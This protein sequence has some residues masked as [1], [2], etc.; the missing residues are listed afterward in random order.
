MKLEQQVVSLEIAKKLKELGVEQ[1]SLFYWH[2]SPYMVNP[3]QKYGVIERYIECSA[4]TVAELGELL[5]YKAHSYR[6]FN[7]ASFWC[8]FDTPDECEECGEHIVN[9]VKCTKSDTEANARGKMLVYLL[10][11]KLLVAKVAKGEKE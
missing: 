5:P 9:I 4:F 2:N 8:T 3:N 10:E 7:E 1:D 6:L 11:N